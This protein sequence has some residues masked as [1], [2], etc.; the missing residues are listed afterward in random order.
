MIAVQDYV[1]ALCG[2]PDVER[3]LEFPAH[4]QQR[5]QA[6]H[7]DLEQSSWALVRLGAGV[8]TIRGSAA[9]CDSAMEILEV[10]IRFFRELEQQGVKDTSRYDSF[11][12][13]RIRTMLSSFE[14][15]RRS[16]KSDETGGNKRSVESLVAYATQ[17]G[18]KEEQVRLATKKLGDHVDVNTLL[19]YLM[20][21]NPVGQEPPRGGPV[22][23][24]SGAVQTVGEASDS[25]ISHELTVDVQSAG[26][27]RIVIDGS[28]VAMA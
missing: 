14:N 12:Y 8:A 25:N 21:H 11:P 18:W 16:A 9:A 4:L 6:R 5:L 22:L 10:F 28:N 17:V 19:T 26:P 15:A 1:R 13:Q 23:S 27:R 3:R 24:S 2:Q 7:L 20:K